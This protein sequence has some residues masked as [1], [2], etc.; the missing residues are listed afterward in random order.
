LDSNLLRVSFISKTIGRVKR[1]TP[2][3]PTE[4]AKEK[5]LHKKKVP[6]VFVE[7]IFDSCAVCSN[8]F[9]IN[10]NK[11]LKCVDC[12]LRVHQ[13]CFGVYPETDAESAAFSCPR[14]EN[15]RNPEAAIVY[16]CILCPFQ[17]K[18]QKTALKKTIGSNWVH[19]QCAIYLPEV[20]NRT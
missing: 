18:E 10:G 13:A 6:K 12:G 2:A 7:E 9:S 16:N 1:K 20:C 17:G 15:K 3:A 5:K 8:K 11:L 14:C 19:Q 4:E